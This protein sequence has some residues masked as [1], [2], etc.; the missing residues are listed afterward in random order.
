MARKAK[1]KKPSLKLALRDTSI[2]FG[3]LVTLCTI[4]FGWCAISSAIGKALH[5]GMV[6]EGVIYFAPFAV[7]GFIVSVALHMGTQE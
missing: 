2:L 5:L 7:V 3:A 4:I 6:G 1:V